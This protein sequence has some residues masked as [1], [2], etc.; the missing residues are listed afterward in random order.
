MHHSRFKG[1]HY[2]AGFHYG[3]LL[4]KNGISIEDNLVINITK[5]RFAYFKKAEKIYKAE[6]P[7]I[8]EEIKG[9]ADG[10]CI[11]YENL[12][13][14][15][16]SMYAYTINNFCTCIVLKTNDN[17]TLF[18]RN[19]D[20]LTSLEKLYESFY[21]QINERYKFI[22]NSTALVQIEDGINE[23]GLAVGLT[24][25]YSKEKVPGL[26]AGMII[27]Y[28]LEKCKTVK[29]CITALDHLTIGS[30]QT[31]TISDADGDMAVIECNHDK[32]VILRPA[33]EKPYVYATNDFHSEQ[34]QR[35]R[36]KLEDDMHSQL[37][38]EVAEKSLMST[39]DLSFEYLKNLLSGKYG[40][41]CQY[42]RSKGGDTV[43][44][45]IYDLTDKKIFRCEGNPS[46]K[47]FIED[48]R[49]KF[50]Q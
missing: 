12:A 32:M 8:L 19:S 6:Y 42:D 33:K 47:I 5:E 4:K 21:Y 10:N 45:C 34:M 46:R 39:K 14:V 13:A 50:S 11:A 18:G 24:F 27:R 16:L 35:Y 26:N 15:L 1:T 43:W 9:M 36:Y 30:S 7:E 29:E 37:R 40:F 44:S 28:L 31:I 22:G 3:A 20:F 25:V 49:M 17:H 2:E 38:Y 48:K 41:M 23:C